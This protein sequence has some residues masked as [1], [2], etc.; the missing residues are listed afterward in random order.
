MKSAARSASVVVFKGDDGRLHGIDER[1]QRRL[2]AFRADA[3]NL[4][5]MGTLHFAYS[6]PRSPQFHRLFFAV[7]K[8]LFER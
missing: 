2:D 5:H 6:V 4:P 3:A 8:A 7:L 1:A